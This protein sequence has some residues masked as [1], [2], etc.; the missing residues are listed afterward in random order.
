MGAGGQRRDRDRLRLDLDAVACRQIHSVNQTGGRAK[1]GP[2]A[3]S[4]MRRAVA[5]G[6]MKPRRPA[7][8]L[9]GSY[10][11]RRVVMIA[12][13]MVRI[14]MV[15]SLAVIG[16]LMLSVSIARSPRGEAAMRDDSMSRGC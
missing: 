8:T 10:A 15:I 5:E 9:G 11:R 1:P 13:C 3:K 4:T 14:I 7:E 16:G 2:H 12:N 6:G